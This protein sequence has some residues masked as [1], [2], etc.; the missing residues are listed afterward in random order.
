VSAFADTNW[1]ESLYFRPEPNDKVATVRHQLVQNRMR[2]QSG[3]LLISHIVLLEARNV[4]GRVSGQPNP[5]QWAHLIAD[6]D[7]RIFVDTMNWDALRRETNR[8]FERFSHKSEIGTFDATL[9]ASAELSG[10][11]E[12]L[13]FDER[14]KAIAMCEDLK[15]FP[16]LGP[17]GKRLVA[18]LK[19]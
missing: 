2:K 4:F 10:A 5:E 9:L 15:V 8:L 16:L 3:P 18:E 7:R 19:K 6:F 17:E 12:I 14:L 1:L 13:S 11:R